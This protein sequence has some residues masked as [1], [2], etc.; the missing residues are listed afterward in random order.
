MMNVL[1]GIV[2]VV[3]DENYEMGGFVIEIAMRAGSEF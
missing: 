2:E 1:D 3:Y